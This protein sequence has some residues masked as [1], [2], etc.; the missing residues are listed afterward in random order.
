MI[1]LPLAIPLAWSTPGTQ[2]SSPSG[3]A[4]DFCSDCL[5]H[6]EIFR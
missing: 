4:A 2:Y 3:I 6:L 1:A 5:A